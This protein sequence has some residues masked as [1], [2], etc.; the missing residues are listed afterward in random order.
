MYRT[1]ATAQQAQRLLVRSTQHHAHA[2]ERSSGATLALK[3]SRR[4][5]TSRTS[6]TH[7]QVACT[8]P[9]QQKRAQATVNPQLDTPKTPL[10]AST[11]QSKWATLTDTPRT[12]CP[13]LRTVVNVKASNTVT[14]PP[15]CPA[16]PVHGRQASFTD[17][18]SFFNQDLVPGVGTILRDSGQQPELRQQK[19]HSSNTQN[20]R[21]EEAALTHQHHPSTPK[22]ARLP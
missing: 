13:A 14:C 9:G 18:S 1:I 8:G 19:R 5:K 15:T 4:S 17:R 10:A 20:R 16:G 7:A 12:M 22:C 2:P 11:K 21:H 3:T 6:G